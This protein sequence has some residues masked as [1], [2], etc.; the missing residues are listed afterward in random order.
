[1]CIIA[2]DPE[3]FNFSVKCGK[4]LSFTISQETLMDCF[5]TLDPREALDGYCSFLCSIAE[6]KA[7]KTHAASVV[8][9]K[10][11]IDT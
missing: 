4:S 9:D 1:M 7:K 6:E 8:I 2:Q 10:E 5:G 11:D 3:T